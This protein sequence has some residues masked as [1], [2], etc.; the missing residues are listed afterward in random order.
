M[1]LRRRNA[2]SSLSFPFRKSLILEETQVELVHRKCRLSSNSKR[3]IYWICKP[4][5]GKEFVWFFPRD[6]QVDSIEEGD[7]KMRQSKLA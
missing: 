5:L 3:K 7:L 6:C 1:T 2:N 4:F